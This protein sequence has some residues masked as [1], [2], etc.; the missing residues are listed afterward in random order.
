MP[1]E[2]DDRLLRRET[3]VVRLHRF[4]SKGG[5]W[6]GDF[7]GIGTGRAAKKAHVRGRVEEIPFEPDE[8]LGEESAFLI[9]PSLKV[10]VL[11]S[12]RL[13][14]TSK[15]VVQFLDKV[16]LGKGRFDLRPI[17]SQSG[18]DRIGTMAKVN[19]FTINIAKMDFS[20][21]L[22]REQH[23]LKQL[24]GL[25]D[26]LQAPKMN[27]EISVGKQWR[28]KGLSV[29]KL[30]ELI[31]EIFSAEEEDVFEIEKAELAGRD[32]D[33]EF[34]FLDL[35]EARLT[36]VVFVEPDHGRGLAMETR[37]R[38]LYDSYLKR[39]EYLR[40]ALSK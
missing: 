22:E 15:T 26:S 16:T 8:G 2:H 28:T 31:R 19:R 9:D 30:R 3:K 33:D 20:R 1:D 17:L 11:Q 21:P 37:W 5:L 24:I 35:T 40:G 25:A 4:A 38:C 7:I 10:L 23:P 12:N 13:A 36:D 34:N 27:I 18:L 39:L 29:D 6:F 14:A 32:E